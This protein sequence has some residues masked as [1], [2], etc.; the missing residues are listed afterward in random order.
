M[1][2]LGVASTCYC[3]HERYSEK[4]KLMIKERADGLWTCK[5]Y[6]LILMNGSVI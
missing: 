1:Q 6:I 2:L 4:Y 5:N 3:E